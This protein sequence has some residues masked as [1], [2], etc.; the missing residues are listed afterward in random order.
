MDN[1]Y[2]RKAPRQIIAF[3]KQDMISTDNCFTSEIARG[4][5]ESL[6][7]VNAPFL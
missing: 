6:C 7:C 4:E 3:I 5:K 1:S 2:K